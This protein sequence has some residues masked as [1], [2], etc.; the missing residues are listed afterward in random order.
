MRDAVVAGRG[1]RGKQ[2][3]QSHMIDLVIYAGMAVIIASMLSV[4]DIG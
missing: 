3:D 1:S 2:G 4:M